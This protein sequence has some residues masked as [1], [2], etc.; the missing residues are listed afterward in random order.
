MATILDIEIADDVVEL[1]TSDVP[2]PE[3]TFLEKTIAVDPVESARVPDSAPVETTV[4]GS[5]PFDFDARYVN[6][7]TVK[8][9]DI[10]FLIPARDLGTFEP[11]PD[12]LVQYDLTVGTATTTHTV[13][14]QRAQRISAGV[15][16]AA[17][18]VHCRE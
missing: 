17:I 9:G 18:I 2:G 15:N 7:E 1:L 10:W 5:P 6:G 13:S 14:V 11:T 12:M 4:Q 8:V 3:Y 16:V